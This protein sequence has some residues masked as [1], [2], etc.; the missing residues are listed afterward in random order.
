M[1]VDAMGL[2]VR[3]LDF[4]VTMCRGQK[5]SEVA[6]NGLVRDRGIKVLGYS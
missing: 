6:G 5:S 2:F 4:R 3:T 1:P